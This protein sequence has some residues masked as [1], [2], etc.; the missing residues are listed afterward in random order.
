MKDTTTYA[1][2]TST[3]GAIIVGRGILAIAWA[4]LGGN[5]EDAE[6]A[7]WFG[8]CQ[9]GLTVRSV[10]AKSPPVFGIAYLDISAV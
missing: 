8:C 6:A 5:N 3:E 2:Q 1:F 10:V 7:R 9:Q 4:L